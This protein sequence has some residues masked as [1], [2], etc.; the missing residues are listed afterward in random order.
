MAL[1][2]TSITQ[3]I[4]SLGLKEVEL[5]TIGLLATLREIQ[6]RKRSLT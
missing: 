4:S 2:K 6:S 5:Q 3:R 1:T